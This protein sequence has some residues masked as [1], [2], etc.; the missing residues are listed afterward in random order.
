MTPDLI[1]KTARVNRLK[2]RKYWTMCDLIGQKN[3]TLSDWPDHEAQIEIKTN[4]KASWVKENVTNNHINDASKITWQPNLLFYL[5][6]ALS[7][8]DADIWLKL[9]R[10]VVRKLSFESSLFST[11]CPKYPLNYIDTNV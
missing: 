11:I 5:C 4:H 1:G 8:N 3:D 6:T 7:T 9:V 2:I 10:S